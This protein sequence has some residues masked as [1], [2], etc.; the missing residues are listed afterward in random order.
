LKFWY[1]FYTSQTAADLAAAKNFVIPPD[2]IRAA[3]KID[4]LIN[5]G[6]YC[7]GEL[8]Y[9]AERTE[10]SI[11]I[12]T[13]LA[14]PLFQLYPPVYNNLGV[15]NGSVTYSET[16]S[17]DALQ[18]LLFGEVDFAITVAG[19][20]KGSIVNE[21][22]DSG[23]ILQLPLFAIR[24]VT[25]F[26]IPGVTSGEEGI[27]L[28]YPTMSDIWMGR[29]INWNHP[30]IQALNPQWAAE[31]RLPDLNITRVVTSTGARELQKVYFVILNYFAGQGPIASRYNLTKDDYGV[32][33][34]Y[35]SSTWLTSLDGIMSVASE[36]KVQAAVLN[37]PGKSYH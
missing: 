1:W 24:M 18:R 17:D 29:I 12:G 8:A 2:S 23:E 32:A 36:S 22:V 33:Q 30:R 26:N 31:G 25:I 20:M 6:M 35:L 3:H 9:P 14:L 4:S 21:A 15:T 27:L 19:V 7:D 34:P 13:S 11:G 37:T 10:I 28:D 16:D 5:S